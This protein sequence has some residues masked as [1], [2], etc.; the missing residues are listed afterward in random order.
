MLSFASIISTL[1]PIFSQKILSN[2]ISFSFAFLLGVKIHHLFLNNS[3]NPDSGPLSSVP[4]IGCDGIQETF[5]GIFFQL[6]SLY[7]L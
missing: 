7:F 5:S 6:N 1:L 3:E 4:A 2:L